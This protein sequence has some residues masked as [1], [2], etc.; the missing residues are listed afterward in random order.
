MMW[1]DPVRALPGTCVGLHE[2]LAWGKRRMVLSQII[3]PLRERF[4]VSDCMVDCS[5][6]E[7]GVQR[8]DGPRSRRIY[9][10]LIMVDR[11]LLGSVISRRTATGSSLKKLSIKHT[12]KFSRGSLTSCSELGVFSPGL[13]GVDCPTWDGGIWCILL[14]CCACRGSDA[15]DSSRST[16]L[17]ASLMSTRNW[18]LS[19]A[20]ASRGFADWLS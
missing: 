6:C 12:Q 11:P 7:R 8:V 2:T 17:T 16:F 5:R 13:D 18:S 1:R 20:P 9:S 19:I 15:A 14:R 10:I 4:I 3:F